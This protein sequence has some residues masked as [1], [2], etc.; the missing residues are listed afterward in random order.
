MPNSRQRQDALEART[1]I[2][3]I[4]GAIHQLDIQ[5]DALSKDISASSD[6]TTMTLDQ[7]MLLLVWNGLQQIRLEVQLQGV[8]SRD[9]W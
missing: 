3:T 6:P 9:N 5:S 4:L 7:K 1:K 8:L 2:D